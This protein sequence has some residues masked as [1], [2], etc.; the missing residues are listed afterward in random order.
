MRT[1]IKGL[2]KYTLML[3]AFFLS[4]EIKAQSLVIN[5]N[6]HQDVSCYGL[7]DGVLQMGASG[8]VKPY[9]YVLANDSNTTGLFDSLSP[10]NIRVLVIDSMGDADSM[11]IVIS[12]PSKLGG[13]ISQIQPSCSYKQDGELTFSVSGGSPGYNILWSD[14]TGWSKSGTKISFLL[15]GTYSVT[16][17][18]SKSCS[19]DT[20]ITLAYS[21]TLEAQIQKTD[22]T[23]FGLKNGVSEAVISGNGSTFSYNWTGP[24]AY[25]NTTAKI[26][27]LSKGVYNLKV[28][29][30]VSGC[31][32]LAEITIIEP[33]KV[34]VTIQSAEDALCNGSADGKIT[35]QTQG[36]RSP[37]TYFWTGPNSYFS[38]SASINNAAAG[39][40]IVQVTDFSGCSHQDTTSISEPNPWVITP[41]I[42]NIQCFGNATGAINLSV[43]GN[44]APYKYSWSNGANTQN[45]AS[46]NSGVYTLTVTDSNACK[47]TR[48][49]SISSPQK[50]ELTHTAT[51]LSCNGSDDGAITLLAAG[52]TFPWSYTTT[53]PN[54]YSSSG[55]TH[56][57][58]KAGTYNVRLSDA[59]NCA[60]SAVI[61]ITQPQTLTAVNQVT[62]PKCFGLKGSFSLT[63]S[64][65]TGPYNYEW[66]DAS[67]AL[68]AATQNVVSVDKGTYY[69][70]VTDAKQCTT[71]D[72]SKI[73]EPT[74]LTLSIGSIKDNICAAD[75]LGEVLVT[76]TGGNNP[77]EYQLGQGTYQS[78]NSFKSLS[79]GRFLVRVRDKNL[80]TDTI[81][82][83]IQYT[84]AVKPN[85][86]LKDITRYVNSNGTVSITLTD[87]DNGI[88]DNCGIQKT[89][90]S[91]TSFSCQDL[92]VNQVSVTVT[93][94]K[95]NSQTAN[96]NVTILDTITPRLKS[97]TASI[98]LNTVGQASLG[99]TLLNDG[100]TDNCGIK[101][102]SVSKS[103]F[104]CSDLGVQSVDF[105]VEDASGNKASKKQSITVLDTIKPTLRYKNL[106]IF[107][108]SSGSISITPQD[109]ND[110]SADNCSITNYEISQNTFD[111][112]N[113][114][115]NF[116]DFSITDI[117]GNKVSQSVRITVRDTF[118]PVL[119]TKPV[120][121]YMNQFGF[122][123]LSPSDIDNGSTDNCKI[124]TRQLSQSVF[125]CGNLGTNS[126]L[127]TLTDFSGNSASARVSITVKDTTVP[128][129][130]TRNTSAYLDKNGF[131]LLSA[132][133][134]D[135]GTADNCGVDVVSLSKDRFV[136]SDLGKNIID[137]T[138]YDK[139]GN[140]TVTQVEI[141]VLDTVK[142]VIRATPKTLY[143]D[144]LGKLSIGADY[145]DVGSFDNC[146]IHK[147]TLS[148]YDFDCSDV[149]NKI[150]LYT[151]ADTSNN[152]ALVV[153][154]VAVRDTLSPKL[155]AENRTVYLD[156]L[157][158]ASISVSLFA[159][160]CSDNCK[161]T[162]L[163]FSDS[164]FDCSQ[165]G[166]NIIQL[167]ASDP[168]GNVA[169]RS[170]IV[171]VFD[172]IS[173]KITTKP[174][175]IYIDTAGKALLN[176][177]QVIEST[178]DNCGISKIELTRTVYGVADIGDNFVEVYAF[179][180]SGNRSKNFFADVRVEVGDFDR[181]SIPDYVER[182]LDF[183]FDGVP[184][185]R[186]RDSDNDGILDVDENSGLTILLD[187]DNDGLKNVYDL[188]TDGDGIF[189]V[190]EVNGFDPDRN[191]TIGVG[192]VV[193]NFWGI[194]V[195]ANEGNAYTEIDTDND[196]IPDYKD[197]DSDDD[198]ISDF[199]ENQK[200]RDLVDSDGDGIA[201]IRDLD[202][203]D[204][205]ISDLIET[206]FDYDQD[207]KGN[208]LDL[209]SDA[210]KISD[211]IETDNDHDN[212]GIGNWLD[213]DS[214][215][216]G[217]LDEIEGAIDSDNDGDGNW[218]DDD[219]D[220]DG[221]SDKLEGQEDTDLDGILD[222]LDRDSDN[223]DIPDI[224]EAQP[225]DNGFPADTDLDG[226]FDYRD[227]D[228]DN[229]LI[230]D[231]TE[232]YP[233][234][235]DTDGDGIP[236]YRDVDSDGDGILDLLE[237]SKDTDSDGIID[238]VDEDADGDGIPDIIETFADIDG[239]GVPNAL[240]LDSDNDGINDVF[241]AG[242]DDTSGRG[243]LFTGQLLT[244]PDTDGDGI[245]DPYD[246]D[247]D[248][249][250]IY[251]I[252]ES[253][254]DFEDNN[255]DGRNDGIDTD[256]D[257]IMDVAD[258][259]NGVYGDFY[260]LPPYD[261]DFDGKPNYVDT[262]SDEDGIL[263][264]IETDADADF[265]FYPNYV[266][267]DS[268]EDGILDIDETDADFDNDGI[269][270][271]LDLDS[272]GDGIEDIQETI[273]D[274]DADGIP[275]YLDLDSD[276][277]EMP[278]Q[279][280]GIL[281]RENNTLLD[282][283]DPQTFTPEIF[284]PNGDGVND[285]FFIKGL[286]N[287]PDASI[288]VFNQWGQI[289]FSSKGPYKNNWDG[290]NTEGEGFKQGTTLPEGIYFYIL[291][292][293][294]SDAPKYI[295]PQTKG[296]VYI[297][298]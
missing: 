226:E 123:V 279:E 223:D 26:T 110:G 216:D 219:S 191:G 86:A 188:D 93:D 121:L 292:H 115:T 229:D 125:T 137:F 262:D 107:L 179:D 111:C 217:V 75:K 230:N 142:P 46:L 36:G 297:K 282:F 47:A 8:G 254:Y 99:N 25:T 231:F 186:D 135:N 55:V 275:N 156:S 243:M 252:V 247:S 255:N 150:L 14:G 273:E 49:Y 165:L 290:T 30:Q 205:G 10:G 19:Y 22:I 198:L 210:D 74:Q 63:I 80:C 81:G 102:Y 16:V 51:A 143:L 189:D 45:I 41:T 9:L 239:D 64:G 43:G 62:Q 136:C 148:Q 167:L 207:G 33:L 246:V 265:D 214:D 241:E 57:N 116:I 109:V 7:N 12:E 87:L 124:S 157:G 200:M 138:A 140:K 206:A 178:Y 77:Y 169:S 271:F 164:I 264:I 258:A 18:D 101:S 104:N 118:A 40:Y 28:T 220:N 162:S 32:A 234:Q 288:T 20:T 237:G 253:Y 222:Y 48:T 259:F 260:E 192:R 274:F 199:V 151:I 129:N 295:K 242:G 170:F 166:D 27:S 96:C 155:Y 266:D 174:T 133:D 106:V 58:L 149:G 163:K 88:S 185:Y 251:D 232:G 17:T 52:G 218:I 78:S 23:C 95:G 193:V 3:I 73:V 38:S 54:A 278:D 270:N 159:N 60:D 296:N 235:P 130:K 224:I 281:D 183:D 4:R 286:R 145:F 176:K 204:D 83:S 72:S 35:T 85:V 298:P 76:A 84:D 181:D 284:S 139:S 267:D 131:A 227:I 201:N 283:L 228:S 194:P 67:G 187:L 65:G 236:D 1:Y 154:P 90:I 15:S 128:A 202:S 34:V 103:T 39:T 132:F 245:L 100:S 182:A 180:G 256:G 276:D 263:D 289:V 42:T 59:N 233:N 79:V 69:Y 113:L 29:E 92:G 5:K 105:T 171:T 287:Y 120:T 212:D 293:N 225:F 6:S 215:N 126:V 152:S 134:V 82:F 112:N 2:P 208:Y 70:K 144:T 117:A 172:T 56:R 280:E 61:Q 209:D 177:S 161:I 37:Y 261:F 244:P 173:P 94:L 13:S 272:D 175:V 190:F 53:G 160:R 248:G 97:K 158:K 238:A 285:V 108:N 71:S 195:L 122:A 141:N 127:Y 257:G 31:T 66:L 24:N 197:L 146:K 119:K 98:Y 196:N 44:T 147:R 294:R 89:D 269:P 68:Y 11:D 184:N 240:D 114:G 221:I 277:D 249:D 168:S 91:K 50:L 203:D 211:K 21:D 250:G 153:L 291:D 213:L 268:D